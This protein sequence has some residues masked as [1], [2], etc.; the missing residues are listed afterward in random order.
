V[1]LFGGAA[2]VQQLGHGEELLEGA[3]LDHRFTTRI[4][5]Q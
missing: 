1:Q 4:N 2:E 5:R 3:Q